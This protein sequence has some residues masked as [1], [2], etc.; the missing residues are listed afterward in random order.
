MQK[1]LEKH[2]WLLTGNRHVDENLVLSQ[3]DLG[4][5]YRTDFAYFWSNS[6]GDFLQLIEIERGGIPV[7][8]SRDEF[9]SDFNHALLQIS[10]WPDWFLRNPQKVEQCLEPLFDNGWIMGFPSYH[11]VKATLIAGRRA[12]V[13]ANEKRRNRWEKIVSDQASMHAELRTWDGFLES[14][15]IISYRNQELTHLRCVSYSKACKSSP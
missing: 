11:H 6:G 2:P 8:T 10:D 4:G 3:F 14:L 12:D 1:H 9:T 5:N 7:F 15:P 13:L